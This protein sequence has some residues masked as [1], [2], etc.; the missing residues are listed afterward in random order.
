MVRTLLG[1]ATI[2][3]GIVFLTAAS[4]SATPF[5]IGSYDLGNHP[6]GN[7]RD[8]TYGFRL[9]NLYDSI[10]ASVGVFTFDF[11][12]SACG[13][14]MVYDGNSIAISGIVSGGEPDGGGGY[15]NNEFDGLYRINNVVYPNV[16][17]LENDGSGLQDIGIMGVTGGPIGTLRFL[18]DGV[19]A[20]PSLTMWELMDKN[21]VARGFPN[22]FRVGNEDDDLGH[23]GHPGISGWGWVLI[24]ADGTNDF[25]DPGG[26]QDWLF[27]ARRVSVPAPGSVVLLLL[28]LAALGTRRRNR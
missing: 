18:G 21:D 2:A 14:T 17:D 13:V 26:A 6:F 15:V 10:G 20:L 12:C 4:A 27:T 23:R 9:D 25:V 28:G 5:E 11:E 22:S 16:V 1:K 8:P 3:F 7:A 24:K 19:D